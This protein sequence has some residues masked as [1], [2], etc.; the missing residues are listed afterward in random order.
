MLRRLNHRYIILNTK[1]SLTPG[2]C[3]SQVK[4]GDNSHSIQ[5]RITAFTTR[6]KAPAHIGV[7]SKGTNNY[8]HRI[9]RTPPKAPAHV[10]VRSKGSTSYYQ[11]YHH[12]NLGAY[13]SQVKGFFDYRQNT[14]KRC[15]CTNENPGD[16]TPGVS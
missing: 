5:P 1:C 2:A 15:A 16:K 13:Q 10:E 11:Q 3:R 12:Q 4:G 9:H 7:R 6:I 14:N 8:N